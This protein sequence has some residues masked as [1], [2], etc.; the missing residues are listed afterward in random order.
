VPLAGTAVAGVTHH[1]AGVASAA[2]NMFFQIGGAIGLAALTT[3]ASTA[4]RHDLPGGPAGHRA[5]AAGHAGSAT[6][7]AQVLEH[8]LAHGWGTAF[9]AGAGFAVLALLVAL[10]VI[11]IRSGE[12]NAA[13][14]H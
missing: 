2:Y 4:I 8:A 5:G 3:V 10:A 7:P 1:D 9:A 6:P 11:H 12:I 14:V 13:H